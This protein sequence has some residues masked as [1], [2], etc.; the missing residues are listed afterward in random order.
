M[1]HVMATKIPAEPL[2]ATWSKSEPLADR[3]GE[4]IA[5]PRQVYTGQTLRDYVPID[6]RS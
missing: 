1:G 4:S 2:S 6:R 5:R 3:P